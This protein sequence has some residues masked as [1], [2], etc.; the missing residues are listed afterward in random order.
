MG[1]HSISHQ[2]P[3]CCH[4]FQQTRA[5]CLRKEMLSLFPLWWTATE[6]LN[7]SQISL[8]MGQAQWPKWDALWFSSCG[9]SRPV[10]LLDWLPRSHHPPSQGFWIF[11]NLGQIYQQQLQLNSEA[12]RHP[13][14]QTLDSFTDIKIH[15]LNSKES[16]FIS[17]SISLPSGE[18]AQC[19]WK[20]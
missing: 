12:Y 10:L 1:R 13:Q 8:H 5:Q 15:M 18:A 2:K 17:L 20:I 4:G 11:G 19:L 9:C 6:T 16:D 3:Y 7:W 14:K